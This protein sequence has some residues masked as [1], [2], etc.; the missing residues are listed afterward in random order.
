M[1][2]QKRQM[3]IHEVAITPF[4]DQRPGTAGLRKKV[5]VF[6]QP[7]YL[8]SFVQSIFDVTRGDALTG[9]GGGLL[10][11]GGDGRYHNRS[12]IQTVIAMAAA[13]GYR[14]VL[15][16]CGGLLSTPAASHV[17][18]TYR[19][20]GGFLLTASHNPAGPD[21]DF[22]IKYNLASGG[23]ATESQTEAIYACS[24]QLTSYRIADLPPVDIDRMG[25]QVFGDFTAEVVDP[26]TDYARLMQQLFDFDRIRALLAGG[27]R[28]RF[29]AMHAVTGP[30]ARRILVEQLGAPEESLR[31][32]EPRE[33]FAGGHP[34]PN[35]VHARPLVDELFGPAAPDFGAASDGDGDRNMILGR[36]I[37][38][39]PGDS[40]AVLAANLHIS[41]G[42]REGL[43]GVARSMPTCRALDVVAARLGLPCFETPTGWRFFCNLL[44]AGRITL[45]GEESFGTGS[46]HVREKDGLWAVL[47]WL[48]IL[49]A[50]RVSVAEVMRDH[51]AQFGRH[52][53]ARHDYEEL[54]TE[55]AQAVTAAVRGQLGQLPGRTPE[56]L[57]AVSAADDFAY[58]DPVDGSESRGQGLRVVFGDAARIV[59]R[60]S[61]TGTAGATLRLYLERYETAADRLALEPAGLLAPL[62]RIADELAGITRL[63]GR[64]QPD[65]VT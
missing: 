51:W 46:S 57:P 34:D 21:G 11:V 5:C 24:R 10:V 18:R 48:D 61:G 1:T 60:L 20:T 19:A 6:Q 32:A 4:Q 54:P 16:G 63:T 42:Y 44:D 8:E 64:A 30:Y 25:L 65:V 26:V 15:I 7:H 38:V 36:G 12:A 45:C 37:F 33:D 13:N 9:R 55:Q 28:L 52:Y 59:L 40:L 35:L 23:Q 29:D 53:Y 62:A 14:R 17:I 47:A 3:R 31:N 56:G 41:P 49:A 22:G 50:R 43:A 27:F 2:N 39:T 58:H